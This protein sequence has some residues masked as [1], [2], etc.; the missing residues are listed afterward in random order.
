MSV[1]SECFAPQVLP[2]LQTRV[3]SREW[4]YKF[5][6]TAQ[7]ELEGLHEKG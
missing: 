2:H 4:R 7:N 5:N 1:N 3:G 6:T